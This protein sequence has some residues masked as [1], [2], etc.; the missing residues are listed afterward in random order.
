MKPLPQLATLAVIGET[1]LLA[2]AWLL[3]LGSEHRLVGDNISELALGRFG[4]IQTLAFVISGL[5]VIG[6]AYTI[7][8][9]TRGSLG[10]FLGSLLI[11]IYGVAGLVVAIF[12]TDRIGLMQRLMIT[13]VS[14][15]LILVALRVRNIAS[16][17]EAVSTENLRTTA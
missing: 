8:Q 1:V 9:L 3:P 6:L 7:H 13:A 17:P 12:P 10:S 4:F 16:A 2:S 14:G 5:A 15:W 11:G